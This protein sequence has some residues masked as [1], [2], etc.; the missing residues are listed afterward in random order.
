[1]KINTQLSRAFAL[2]GAVL[3]VFTSPLSAATA[4]RESARQEIKQAIRRGVQFLEKSQDA[5]TGA[6]GDAENPAITALATMAIVGD[7]SLNEGELPASAEKSYAA[8]IKHEKPDGGI[9]VKGLANYNTS[10]S[11]TALMVHP[12]KSHRELAQKARRFLIGLQQD[13]GEPGQSDH[14]HDGG[15]GYGGSS[16]L[17]DLSNTHFALEALYY[18]KAL[19]IEQPPAPDAPKLN[20]AAA[21]QFISRCQNLKK[22]NDQPWASDDETN[23]GGFIYEPGK[24]K[25]EDT[26]LPEGKV[27]LRSY[28]S[29]SYAGLLSLVYAQIPPTDPR[30][31]AVLEW[32]QKNYTLAEN[33]GMGQQGLY[34]YYHTMA[35]VLRLLDIDELTTASGEK[36]AW[37]SA[38]STQL[39]KTQKSDGSWNNE[40]ARWR[41][42]DAVYATALAVLTL[43]HSYHS[44]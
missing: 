3:L 22:S 36:I 25:A 38:L 37:A 42:S 32:L 16:P 35:K 2:C 18:A 11:L 9:Y 44:L 21:I 8:L 33:P 24:S 34:Y 28:G 4:D 30:A 29:I 17:T 26:K 15:I 7:P 19:D 31:T 14:P 20:Y 6:I 10:L 12:K 5:T 40:T 43:M 13:H 1:M 39:L 41:E 27:A 23:K